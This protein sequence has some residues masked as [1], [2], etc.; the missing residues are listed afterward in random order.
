VVSVPR[1]VVEPVVGFEVGVAVVLDEGTMERVGATA[2][3]EFK[4]GATTAT[5]TGKIASGNAAELLG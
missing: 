2:G 1:V 4:L 3:D 5:G